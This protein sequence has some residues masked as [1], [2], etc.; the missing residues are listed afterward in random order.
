MKHRHLWKKVGALLLTCVLALTACN[1]FT[2]DSESV[3]LPRY[4]VP[5]MAWGQGTSMTDP[6]SETQEES[7]EPT[8]E[9]E[10]IVPANDELANQLME[11]PGVVKV[12]RKNIDNIRF[13]ENQYLIYYEMPIDHN[14][15][16][17]GTFTQRLYLNYKGKDA[18]NDFYIG[19]Y[20]I[21]YGVHDEK[22]SQLATKYNCNFFEAEYRFDGLSAPEGFSTTELDYWEYLNCAQASE[23]FHYMIE[24][25]KNIFSGKW[26]IEGISKGGEFTAY[27]AEK[28][29]EDADLY[30]AESAMLKCNNAYPGLYEY[31]YT[32]AGDD[33]YGK[34]QAQEYRDLM[35][36]FQVELI[37]HRDELEDRYWKTATEQYGLGFSS[38][39]TKELLF[40]C[41]VIDLNYIWQFALEEEF[42]TIRTAME[43]KP[44]D[45]SDKL[46]VEYFY[47]K[48]IEAILE[49]YGPWQYALTERKMASEEGRLYNYLFQCATEDGYYAYDFSHLRE[50][51]E[52]DGSGATLFVT[53]DMEKDLYLL[54]LDEKHQKAFPYNDE[55]MQTRCRAV[56]NTQKP[57]ILVNPTTDVHYIAE[58]TESNNP[59]V[60]IFKVIGGGHGDAE[61]SYLTE[62]QAQEYEQ[63]VKQALGI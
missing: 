10:D 57:M 55:V 47:Q 41:T 38:T 53:E 33:T 34:D 45:E 9:G 48:A 32:T 52:K 19:G 2:Q 50:A 24:G 25:F 11:L 39:F 29:P 6:G 13:D 58:I 8:T 5:T 7:W 35:L 16:A 40:D 22:E 42:E 63:V 26:C 46:V 17:K 51:L 21:Y 49:V 59:N 30:V 43:A 54:R 60:H 4:T 3:S 61:L 18:P 62:K 27:Q 1:R 14:D 20:S 15:P 36:E 23:D 37:K 31:M 56:E 12:G 28:H 44:K